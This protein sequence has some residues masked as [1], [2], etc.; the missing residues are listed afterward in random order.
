[1]SLPVRITSLTRA[2]TRCAAPMQGALAQPA[3]GGTRPVGGAGLRSRRPGA[4]GDQLRC[5]A[6]LSRGAASRPAARPRCRRPRRGGRW[7][8]P[9]K[10]GSA[11]PLSE[12][13][14]TTVASSR[15]AGHPHACGPRLAPAAARRAGRC[16]APR[17]AGGPAYRGGD[18]RRPRSPRQPISLSARHAVGTDAT[19]P[20]I[21]RWSPITRKSLITRALSAIAHARSANTRPRSM[22]A[23]RRRQRRRQA[24]RQARSGPKAAAAARPACDTIPVPPPV[25][26]RPRDHPVAFTQKSAP[27]TSTGKDLDNPY[28]PSSGALLYSATPLTRRTPTESPGLEP[29]GCS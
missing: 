6:R 22:A 2:R 10:F 3:A 4:A 20:N 26:S 15:D 13:A 28:R 17:R 11:S 14:C 29:P 5:P 16:P 21:S 25:T 1:M 19:G 27:R 8:K 23:Q 12:Q 7:P 18:L 9:L 24:R